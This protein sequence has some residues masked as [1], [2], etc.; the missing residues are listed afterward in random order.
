[1]T[2]NA[3]VVHLVNVPNFWK[4]RTD[5]KLAVGGIVA[6]LAV[7][8]GA[9]MREATTGEGNLLA[10]VLVA[11]AIVGLLVLYGY[12]RLWNA[13]L[14]VRKGEVGVTN[15]LGLSR[16]VRVE[17]VDHFRRTAEVWTGERLPRG[18]L[19]IVTKDRKHSI[20]FGGGDR[21]EPGGL[22]RIAATVGAPIEGSW[23]DLPTWHP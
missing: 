12:L 1:V 3:L 2:D 23:T 17:S 16:T 4:G 15:W 11:V 8:V 21:L 19:F 20:R 14:F 6:G 10:E 22:E 7:I 5:P 9:A 18:V 13:T